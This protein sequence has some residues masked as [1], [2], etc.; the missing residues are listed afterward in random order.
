MRSQTS[1]KPEMC[2]VAFV[3]NRTTLLG[4]A[5]GAASPVNSFLALL[6]LAGKRAFVQ[7]D[8]LQESLGG[9]VHVPALSLVER[10]ACLQSEAE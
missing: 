5:A 6:A 4:V 8:E 1:D 9:G 3:H 10:L 7:L 2:A